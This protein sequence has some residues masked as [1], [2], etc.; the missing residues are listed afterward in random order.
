VSFNK[1][2][3]N[4]ITQAKRY[5]NFDVIVHG[6]NC[7]NAMGGGIAYEISLRCPNASSVDEYFSRRGD[8]NKLGKIS[9]AIERSDNGFPFVVVNAYTQFNPGANFKL[10]ALTK[11]LKKIKKQ[12]GGMGLCF[13]FPLIGAGIGGG[14]WK[15]IEKEIKTILKDENVYIVEYDGS[16]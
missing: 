2:K 16:K 4:L 6:C 10:K 1:I 14:D 13:G 5:G 15:E 8:K 3:G 11:C 9:Y 7:Q 12:F